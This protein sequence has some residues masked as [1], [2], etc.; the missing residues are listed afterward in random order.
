MRNK[1]GGTQKWCTNC[2]SVRVVKC[3]PPGF[4]IPSVS[5]IP[6]E[7]INYFRRCQECQTCGHYWISAEVPVD[8]I[9][10]LVYL[11]AELRYIKKTSEAHSK[12]SEY[13]SLRLL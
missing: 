4:A 9:Q 3:E 6:F 11:R 1:Q 7:D 10:E 12:E 13:G 2:Q 8:L 5:S